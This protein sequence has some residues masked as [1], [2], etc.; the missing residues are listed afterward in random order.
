MVALIRV[1][2]SAPNGCCAFS[3]DSTATGVPVDRSSRVATT[4]V[5]PRSKAMPNRRGGGVAR[6]H[7]DQHVVHDHRG[8][9]V[10]RLRA[11]SGRGSCSTDSSARGSRSSSWASTRSRSLAWSARV[12]SASSR[13]R[14]CTRRA[15]DDLPADADGGG[16]GPGGQ[17]RH[18]DR[19]VPGGRGA[20]GQP[21]AVLDLLRRVGPDVQA[22]RRGRVLGD[23]DPALLAGAVAAAG[24][25]DGD[26]VPA[27]RVEQ[28]HAVRNPHRPVIE[29]QIDPNGLGDRLPPPSS[30]GSLAAPALW[31]PPRPALPPSG[32]PGARRSSWRP[33]RRGSAPG[34]R[35]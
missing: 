11:A 25:V 27:G 3:V 35:P 19:R 18:L 6:L 26:A 2:T 24:R 9:L 28:G 32:R 20:A 13:Y 8:D 5:V 14:F 4:V 7:G 1:I 34:R 23:P 16:L 21:P 15:Q 31:L 12:G 17:R 29:D 30:R 22:G 33:T 10:V